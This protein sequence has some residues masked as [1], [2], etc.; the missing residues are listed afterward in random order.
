MAK[1]I[2]VVDAERHTVRLV[3]KYLRQ[4]GYEVVT[5]YDGREALDKIESEKPDLMVTEIVLPI[6]DGFEVLKALRADRKTAEIPVIAL[7]CKGRDADIFRGWQAGFEC[8]LTKP[9][10]DNELITFVRRALDTSGGA[11]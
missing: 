10:S 9:F 6:L 3:E 8:Y 1:K 4:A 5:A 11:S 2:L 7:T